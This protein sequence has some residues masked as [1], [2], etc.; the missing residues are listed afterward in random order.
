[1]RVYR[2]LELVAQLGSGVP[3]ILESYGR[4]C[5][6]FM[7][8]FIRMTFPASE[9]VTPQVTSP[10]VERLLGVFT[11]EH[12]RQELQDFLGLSDRKNFRENYLNPAIQAGLVELVDPNNPTSSKQ[13]Y[14]LTALGMR[15][16]EKIDKN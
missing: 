15:M 11:G 4:E 12:N 10:Q 14:V 1:M 9:S 7:G 5:F 3:R 6:R 8:N 16:A 2:D 13:R